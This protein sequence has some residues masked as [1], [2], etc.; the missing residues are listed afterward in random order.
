MEFKLDIYNQ[1]RDDQ[2][3][4]KSE[5]CI[6]SAIY[7][8]EEPIDDVIKR[9]HRGEGL[10]IELIH[11]DNE[12]PLI[13]F[14]NLFGVGDRGVINDF[15]D[16]Y[17]LLSQDKIDFQLP[18][19]AEFALSVGEIDSMT[20]GDAAEL[21]RFISEEFSHEIESITKTI[22][23]YEWGASGYFVDFL[24]NLAA[25]FSQTGIQ[26]IYEFLKSK[27]YDH[28][29]INQFDLRK[30]KM[31]LE[32][33]YQINPANLKLTSTRTYED[34]RTQLTFSTRYEDYNVIVDKK[35]SIIESTIRRLNQTNI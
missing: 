8:T 4:V 29:S 34:G 13:R 24:I 14:E 16:R 2:M 28:A 23:I 17:Q 21:Q 33:T 11:P 25:G 7:R 35:S 15:N 19:L 22:S 3:R 32:K 30:V 12:I 27:G 6:Y 9:L 10:A 1:V 26:R 20:D 18:S 5:H 31:F